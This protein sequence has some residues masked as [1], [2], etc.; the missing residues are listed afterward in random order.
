MDDASYVPVPLV[1]DDQLAYLVRLFARERTYNEIKVLYLEFWGKPIA[2]ETIMQIERDYAER[3]AQERLIEQRDIARKYLA[4]SANR[5]DQIEQGLKEA[6]KERQ[7]GSFRGTGMDGKDCWVPEMGKDLTNFRGFI[8]LARKEEEL[9]KRLYLDA[10]KLD[11]EASQ[12][13]KHTIINVD[14]G[15][16]E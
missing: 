9:Q 1:T 2:P 13:R 12:V 11:I 5:L 16:L 14:T 7:I 15:E 4:H 8:D 6:W 3:I 10:I